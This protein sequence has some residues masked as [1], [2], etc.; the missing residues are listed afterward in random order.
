MSR[1][2]IVAPSGPVR[3]VTPI[4][5][6]WSASAPARTTTWNDSVS[7]RAAARLTAVPLPAMPVGATRASDGIVQTK[8]PFAAA[9]GSDA[10]ARAA[11]ANTVAT[12]FPTTARG[13]VTST[14]RLLAAPARAVICWRGGTG[15]APPPERTEH[16]GTGLNN[17]FP[18]AGRARRKL[19]IGTGDTP[20]AAAADGTPA[21]LADPAPAPAQRDRHLGR[22][23][24]SPGRDERAL[25]RPQERDHQR[26]RRNPARA[27]GQP[28]GLRQN[29][30]DPADHPPV[31]RGGG[32]V[33]RRRGRLASPAA[34]RRAGLRP[35]RPRPGRRP[36]GGARGWAGGRPAGPHAGAGRHAAR[37]AA[38]DARGR[39]PLLLLAGDGRARAGDP[40][41]D[42]GLRSPAG[43]AV[44]PRLPA[45]GRGARPVGL[46]AQP[47]RPGVQGR[48]RPHH[49]RARP[50]PAG[51]PAARPVRRA[52]RRARPGDRRAFHARPAPRPD[53]DPDHRRPR[54]D[55]A[56]AVLVL[57]P[58]GARPALAGAGG[59]GGGG[60]RPLARGSR[61]GRRQAAGRAR[62]RAGGAA[63]LPAGLHHRPAGQGAGRAGGRGGAARHAGRHLALAAA[64]P[65]QALAGP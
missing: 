34:P 23:R 4:V 46:A 14:I 61:R 30:G 51:R 45:L 6:S 62:R 38:A 33:S 19:T 54:D 11:A 5:T 15:T 27:R 18:R 57:L 55:R 31:A 65:P 28:R 39:R 8:A 41:R 9:A 40:G 3:S 63:P 16:A 10:T 52:G 17:T 50:H 7:P 43:P 53:R 12:T 24:L 36:G 64:P 44:L 25:P 59:R 32:A 26:A 22:A 37:D 58:A 47:R 60:R 20:L 49:R 1:A 2:A 13:P 56:V 35:A 42:R 21:A 29:T 48:A